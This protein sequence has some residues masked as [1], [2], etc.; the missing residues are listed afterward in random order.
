MLYPHVFAAFLVW[1]GLFLSL[2]LLVDVLFPALKKEIVL[3]AIEKWKSKRTKKKK[4]KKHDDDEFMTETR[5]E[6]E[7]VVKGTL[8]DFYVRILGTLHA[9]V[10][11][12]GAVVAVYENGS[13]FFDDALYGT[14]DISKLFCVIACGYF[15]WD[16]IICLRY[17]WGFQFIAH[18]ATCITSYVCTLIP[19]GQHFATTCLLFE[20]STPLLHG[21]WFSW[22][23]GMQSTVRL[24]L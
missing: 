12:Y 22:Q 11:S 2:P 17:G 10:V 19:F 21:R 14:S 13:L 8:D 20:L 5:K 9:I 18:A 15:F 6:E 24:L 1:S 7:K 23:R 16:I 4:K 3:R